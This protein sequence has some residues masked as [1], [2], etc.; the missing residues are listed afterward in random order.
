MSIIYEPKGKA[1]EYS[2]LAA[3]FYEGCDHGCK[4]CYAPGIRR[5]TRE[6]YAATVTPRRDILKE[7]S[8]DLKGNCRNTPQVLFNFMGDPYCK[9]DEKDKV[10]RGALELLLAAHVPVAILTKGGK[11]ALRDIDIIK[12]FGP[13]IKV[14]ATL[15]FYSPEK[16]KEWE[17]G[18]ASPE[19]RMAML[20]A[21]HKEG[22]K[23]WASFE[24]VL[25][26][27][28][29]IK[30]IKETLPIVDEY[31]VG[32][33][34]N[35]GGLDKTID[36]TAFLAE[37]VEILRSARKPFYIKHDLRQAAP[38]I[39]LYGNEVLPDEFSLSPWGIEE[40]F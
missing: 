40:L 13:H 28:E 30:L 38:S 16:S 12:K 35:F 29:A 19:E 6:D 34:N 25:D 27:I 26:P 15:T 20:S 23:T 31:K 39:K 5:M 1:R 33:I 37:V 24:P 10:T 3:N 14:G 36:W 32:K 11:R 18:A 22:V 2:P 7:L 17:P 8:K 21:F 9:G 4:Y